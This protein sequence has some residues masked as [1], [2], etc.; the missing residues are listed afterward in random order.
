MEVGSMDKV[1][2]RAVC[3]LCPSSL[4][5]LVFYEGMLNTKFS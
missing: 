3:V 2:S 5:C 1:P 4:A